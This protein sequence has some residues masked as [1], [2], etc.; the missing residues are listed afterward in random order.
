[1]GCPRTQLRDGQMGGADWG[2]LWAGGGGE[3]E[4]GGACSM[5]V[6]G[7]LQDGP[8]RFSTEELMSRGRC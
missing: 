1:M 8:R 3:A 6:T 4:A 5:G 2:Q 7:L